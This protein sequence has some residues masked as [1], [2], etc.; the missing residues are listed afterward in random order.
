MNLLSDAGKHYK[1]IIHSFL[2]KFLIRM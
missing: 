2:K 1:L